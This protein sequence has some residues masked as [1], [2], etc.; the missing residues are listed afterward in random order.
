MC[1][2]FDWFLYKTCLNMIILNIFQADQKEKHGRTKCILFLQF[3]LI[4]LQAVGVAICHQYLVD[5]QQQQLT[6]ISIF[7]FFHYKSSLQPPETQTL[8][9]LQTLLGI[10]NPQLQFCIWYVIIGGERVPPSLPA[11]IY[12]LNSQIFKR[13]P[14]DHL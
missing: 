2:T 13:D 7:I 4:L 9:P 5:W 11:G 6:V 8:T 12:F 1:Q 10:F 14:H 3:C